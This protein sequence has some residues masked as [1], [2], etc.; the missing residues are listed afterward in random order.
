M[1]EL[2]LNQV[3][4]ALKMSGKKKYPEFWNNFG[5]VSERQ[6][7]VKRLNIIKILSQST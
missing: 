5:K 1:A 4:K 3:F 2:S 7:L 6:K